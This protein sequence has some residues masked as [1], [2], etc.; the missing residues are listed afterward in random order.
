MG[1]RIAEA[2][3]RDRAVETGQTGWDSLTGKPREV[4][5]ERSAY[6]GRKWLVR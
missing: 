1:D 3:S 5:L 2:E 6:T 4:S